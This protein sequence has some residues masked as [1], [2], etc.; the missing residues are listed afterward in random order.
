MLNDNYQNYN[1]IKELIKL[2]NISSLREKV[3]SETTEEETI[4]YHRNMG[5]KYE[6]NKPMIN[7]SFDGFQKVL[8]DYWIGYIY[9]YDEQTNKW[10]WDN[11]TADT[12]NLNLKP[13]SDC[14]KKE[15]KKPLAPIIGADGNVFNL[16]G[17]CS[18][19]LKSAG[20]PDKAT[21]MTDR[22]TNSRSYDEALSIMCEYI[23]PV[24]QNYQSFDDDYEI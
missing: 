2:G 16:I 8:F 21:E 7:K 15:F 18:R 19:A 17:I 22:I 1:D 10:L 23:E 4:A 5:E 13:L 24:D 6:I 14:F 11:Y 9:L 20:Y 12:S 3:K